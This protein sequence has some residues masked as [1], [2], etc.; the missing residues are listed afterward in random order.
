MAFPLDADVLSFIW[1]TG[2]V[3]FGSKPQLRK[4][5]RPLPVRYV[6]ELVDESSL[7]DQ[8]KKYLTP[9]DTQLA[10]LS[11]RPICTYRMTNYGSNLIRQ[12]HNAADPASC[13]LTIVEVH[14]N[15]RA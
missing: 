15:V 11:Y 14:T 4:N 13:T 6:R 1:T 10:A 3:L 2:V 7:T 5:S 8:Q 9:L 12:Y